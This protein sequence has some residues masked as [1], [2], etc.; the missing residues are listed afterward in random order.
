LSRDLPSIKNL[1]EA[2]ENDEI[3]FKRAFRWNIITG[4]VEKAMHKNITRVI[5]SLLN[6]NGGKIII[7]VDDDCSI[8]GVEEDIISYNQNDYQKGKDLLLTDL[9]EKIRKNIGVTANFNCKATFKSIDGHEILIIS[10]SKSDAPYFHLKNEFYVRSQNATIKLSKEE[11]FEYF[12]NR[13]NSIISKTNLEYIFFTILGYLRLFKNLMQEKLEYYL[14]LLIILIVYF[15]LWYIN[16]FLDY[17]SSI[18]FFPFQFVLLTLFLLRI[19]I[20]ILK[21]Y[22]NSN[23]QQKSK[24]YLFIK[25]IPEIKLWLV[26]TIFICFS[27]SFTLSFLSILVLFPLFKSN[28]WEL[29]IFLFQILSILIIFLLM[30]RDIK[31]FPIFS[32]DLVRIKDDEYTE[33]NI[34]G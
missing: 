17:S 21:E 24:Q 5:S 12:K 34:R 1:I 8:L 2:H 22:K 30:Y 25:Y 9:G 29:I 27:L 15:F 31:K 18:R 33:K 10:V 14:S 20:D 26:I 11:T 28:F 13:F 19:F 4:K 16:L 7:G 32:S 3:E 6:T 23:S